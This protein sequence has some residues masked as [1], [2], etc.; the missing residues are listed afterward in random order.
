LRHAIKL[1]RKYRYE[2]K[3]RL[4]IMKEEYLKKI[5]DIYRE[6]CEIESLDKN[7]FR[8]SYFVKQILELISKLKQLDSNLDYSNIYENL[9]HTLNKEVSYV[10]YAYG[11]MIKKNAAKVRQQEYYSELNKAIGQIRLDISSL[12]GK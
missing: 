2:I 5:N 4:A 3:E 9:W 12:L 8:L 1:E 11:K 6:I 10:D 7:P